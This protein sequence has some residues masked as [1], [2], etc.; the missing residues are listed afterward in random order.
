M[1]GRPSNRTGSGPRDL[2]ATWHHLARI[3]T[4]GTRL[5]LFADFDG[6][7]APIQQRPARVRIPPRVRRLLASLA[8]RGHLVGIVSGRTLDDVVTRV[9]IPQ[10]WY[11]GDQGF[12]LRTP[13]AH[14]VVLASARQRAAMRRVARSLRRTLRNTEGLT[15]ETK[16]A[17]LTVHFRG[18]PPASR[19]A[20][21]RAVQAAVG[22]GSGL[23]MMAGKQ[24]WEVLPAAPFDK[25]RAVAFIL[26]WARRHSPPAHWLPI[27][28]GDDVADEKV[29]VGWR[30]LSVLV[31]TRRGTAARYFVRS[32]SDVRAVLEALNHVTS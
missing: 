9:G 25:A 2:L 30:G 10:V 8:E 27:Y 28:I 26:R 13:T 18:A 24:I 12:L 20:A 31:G 14:T 23:Q 7:L 32:P 16:V 4:P 19:R 15:V 11:V 29:F 21:R 1:R 5:A 3:I 6:T 17:T 22:D